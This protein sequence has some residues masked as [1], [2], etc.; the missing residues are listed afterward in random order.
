MAWIYFVQVP[1]PLLRD[2]SKRCRPV[3]TVSLGGP[4]TEGPIKIGYTGCPRERM[5][6]I[7]NAAN[8][9]LVLLGV[10]EGDRKVER[11]VH[12][13]FAHLHIGPR[14]SLH[15]E[16]FRPEIDLLDVIASLPQAQA[17]ADT[18]HWRPAQRKTYADDRY[19]DVRTDSA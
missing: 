8:Q 19:G 2:A 10:L 4:F 5:Y 16:W 3:V 14:G 9:P 12:K 1:R 15:S 18:K 17:L 6:S 11:L 13:A 7:A